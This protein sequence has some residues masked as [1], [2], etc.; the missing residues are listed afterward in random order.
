MKL[1]TFVDATI[2]V[3]VA[4]IAFA[5]GR[6]TA[7][8]SEHAR[9]ADCAVESYAGA[10]RAFIYGSFTNV[11]DPLATDIIS[12]NYHGGPVTTG[13]L[14]TLAMAMDQAG[15]A[16]LIMQDSRSRLK[17][18]LADQEGFPIEVEEL[19]RRIAAVCRK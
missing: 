14:G 7:P 1:E 12:P 10:P 15:N 3:L 6:A 11:S 17:V 8:T 19:T 5:G 4:V 13:T 16:N 2:V 18:V 9:P